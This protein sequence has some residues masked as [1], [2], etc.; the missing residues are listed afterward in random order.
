V[1]EKPSELELVIEEAAC[2]RREP[3]LGVRM[4]LA[5]IGPGKWQNTGGDKAKFGL[6]APVARYGAKRLGEPACC[7]RCAAAF[8]H[9]LADR[10][11]ARHRRAACARR[12]VISSSCARSAPIDCM[13][14]GGGLGVDYEGTRS[15][16]FL[17]DQL[18]RGP[19]RP[20]SSQPLAEACHE[21]GW[22]RIP[23]VVTES[24]RAMTA[25]HA[26]LVANV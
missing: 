12:R 2:A 22:C 25:H 14:V 17:L 9:G 7:R 19:I 13:D 23:R 6:P 21:H 1:V 3:L 15:R 4:R 10:E 18:R 11:R 26:V 8:P 16:S 5:S 24:G 20:T